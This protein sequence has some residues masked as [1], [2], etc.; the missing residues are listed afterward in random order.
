MPRD[1]GAAFQKF[2]HDHCFEKGPAKRMSRQLTGLED[3]D[4]ITGKSHIV[5][6]KLWRLHE[7]LVEVSFTPTTIPQTW[8][9]IRRTDN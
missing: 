4:Q 5:E 9:A 2:I 3:A 1:I 6:I 8:L 7:T